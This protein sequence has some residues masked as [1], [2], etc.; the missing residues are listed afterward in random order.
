MNDPDTIQRLDRGQER[1]RAIDENI[2]AIRDL[3]EAVQT[4]LCKVAGEVEKTK[5][6]VEAWQTVKNAGRFTK[7][8]AGIVAALGTALGAVGG[9]WIVMKGWCVK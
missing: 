3:V 7:W 8:A 2:R 6:I 9:A 1:F 4:H 5:D